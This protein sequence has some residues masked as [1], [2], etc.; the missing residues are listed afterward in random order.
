MK[1]D[2]NLDFLRNKIG[3]IK[4]ALC[5]IHHPAL[6]DTSYIVQ[7]SVDADG[8]IY[9]NLINASPKTTYNDLS[10]F[11]LKLLYYKKDLD[12]YINIEAFASVVL[13]VSNSNESVA[14]NNNDLL[15]VK[16]KILSAVYSEDRR[17][18][19]RQGWMYAIRQ[20]LAEM[21]HGWFLVKNPTSF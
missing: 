15:R 11:G 10:C 18:K 6:S 21:T 20:K 8:Y 3:E 12:Y 14:S 9:F 13:P 5:S 7:T 16:A 17:S 2:Y 19:N 4:T 1:K